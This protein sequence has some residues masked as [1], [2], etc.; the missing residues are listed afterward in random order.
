MIRV[1][2][3][4]DEGLYKIYG[5]EV[6]AIGLRTERVISFLRAEGA[7]GPIEVVYLTAGGR[8]C[9]LVPEDLL[10][11]L[12]RVTFEE[13]AWVLGAAHSGYATLFLPVLEPPAEVRE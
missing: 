7:R 10:A 11:A 5:Q 4:N 8:P 12:R 9:E 6:S 3:P 13:G 2:G 1:H